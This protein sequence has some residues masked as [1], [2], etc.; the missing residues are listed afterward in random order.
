MTLLRM[1]WNNLWRIKIRHSVVLFRTK[2][3]LSYNRLTCR[4]SMMLY[5]GY[6]Y[7]VLITNAYLSVKTDSRKYKTQTGYNSVIIAKCFVKR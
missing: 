1:P 4:L 2:M 6:Y 7:S 3:E 5:S